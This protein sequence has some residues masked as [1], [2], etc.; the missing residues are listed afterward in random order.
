MARKLDIDTYTFLSGE[1]V[2]DITSDRFDDFMRS[3]EGDLRVEK[4]YATE[5]EYQLLQGRFS[6][7][8]QII[9]TTMKP[10]QEGTKTFL[11]T[12]EYRDI[13]EQMMLF[14]DY[15][16]FIAV[17]HWNQEQNRFDVATENHPE[18]YD[19]WNV[20]A[21]KKL[22][23]EIE[24]RGS[25]RLNFVLEKLAAA[26][27]EVVQDKEEY[28]W[29]KEQIDEINITLEMLE[30]KPLAI[31]YKEKEIRELSTSNNDT[32]TR[33]QSLVRKNILNSSNSQEVI[34]NLVSL[35]NSKNKIDA[36]EF[37][38]K[39]KEAFQ[40]D[41]NIASTYVHNKNGNI[42]LRL[43]NH[44]ANA[45]D[46]KRYDKSTSIVIKLA[47][48][49]NA[50]KFRKS[51]E[52]DLIEFAYYPENLT[53]ESEKAIVNGL[54]DWVKTGEYTYTQADEVHQSTRKDFIKKHKHNQKMTYAQNE[55]IYGFTYDGK[56]YLNPEIANSEV[57]LHEY[58]HLWDNYTQRTNPEL[59]EKGKDIL[60]DTKFWNEVKNDP[61]Y[62]DFADSDDLLLSEV[63]AQ[64]C[65]K[66][67]ESVLS[68]IQEQ[69]GE[70]TKDT[71]IDWD[72]EVSEF[73]AKEFQINPELGDENYISEMIRAENLK[74][75]LSMPMKDFMNGVHITQNVEEK[76]IDENINLSDEI[77]KRTLSDPW[78]RSFVAPDYWTNE[79]IEHWKALVK[80]K[81]VEIVSS[82]EVPY[83]AAR[84]LNGE[85]TLDTIN[86]L[87]ELSLPS[88][89][90]TVDQLIE[91]EKKDR[92]YAWK[93]SR[94]TEEERA[95]FVAGDKGIDEFIEQIQS[96]G[97]MSEAAME[98][99]ISAEENPRPDYVDE[100][101]N[102]HSFDEEDD[103][104]VESQEPPES[105]K[106]L[107][108]T[109][110]EAADLLKNMQ[111]TPENYKKLLNV[112][113]EISDMNG[114]KNL[115]VPKEEEIASKMSEQNNENHETFKD[116]VDSFSETKAGETLKTLAEQT[117]GL[118][119]GSI[120]T[121]QAVQDKI[122]EAVHGE[123][124]KEEIKQ[125]T[126]TQTES[127]ENGQEKPQQSSDG[128]PEIVF[129]E[130]TL[131]TFSVLVGDK[132]QP[133]ENAVVTGH[134]KNSGSYFVESNG[135]KFELPKATFDTLFNDKVEK[136]RQK[137]R[138]AE[139][140]TIVFGDKERGV[141]GT[142]I[143]EW[144]MYTSRGLETFKGFVPVK[145]NKA[146]DS[147][148]L[149]NGDQTLTVTAEK[150]REITAPE[151]FENKFD[152][153]SPAWKKLC[154]TQYKDFF[155]PRDST[156][157]NFR[158]NLSVYCRR[159]AT[160][161]CDALR[162]AKG[163]IEKMPKDEQKKTQR[164]LKAMA[165]ENE[166]TME[167][168]ARLYHE[169]IKEQ[170][171]NEDYMKTWQPK[172]V[173]ARP[174][175]DT[176]SSDGQ[177]VDNDPALVRGSEDRNLK[178]GMSLKNV[179]IETGK[180]F[181]RGKDTMHFD[182]LK[183]ISSSKEG[184]SVTLMDGNKSIFKLPR[185][186]VLKFYKEQQLREMKHEHRQ[187]RSNTMTLGYA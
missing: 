10:I 2:T 75:F 70:L 182:E 173:V 184:N 1:K 118:P 178:I 62:A 120:E 63:H 109:L 99:E 24:D 52:S 76:S 145:F 104:G 61:N 155:E 26:G 147:Y 175:Y 111:F 54:M 136:E 161:P 58:T 39:L 160:S 119:E 165:H 96:N 102:P 27:I 126:L 23:E 172:K 170:P 30:E 51:P 49:K 89:I 100:Q 34:K 125:E 176:I 3:F 144:S 72:K 12:E 154:E 83:H 32:Q 153:D 121:A 60:K 31:Q 181:G 166:S 53:L 16:Q 42:E 92:D 80:E 116:A 59:W 66:M 65:G 107:K 44:C 41:K 69:D 148:T 133:I 140:K 28:Q 4:G 64:I 7:L 163:L 187:N 47:R 94:L 138:I 149:S 14:D 130:T 141:K 74:D 162:I 132:M 85:E 36:E 15:S 122:Y 110:G 50:P 25:Q 108:S 171:L 151:R 38:S 146:E 19:N 90:E 67:A 73:I 143:P 87:E 86:N 55:Q 106:L 186:T 123:P 117:A 150:F 158:H 177:K 168:I 129:G 56:I 142:E 45:S 68:R 6:I 180:L 11:S 8:K 137:A 101:G 5:S 164:L 18:G 29:M 105:E 22:D 114:L 84:I 128:K 91:L 174:F 33:S 152:E 169:A 98:A 95:E 113:N 57:A 20:S 139:G 124:K 167:L 81:D 78:N 48:G 35:G 134:D 37:L 17:N 135:E 43:S 82:L 93:F 88:R 21:E 127:E 46:S 40:L 156:A 9:E 179:D 77:D 185:D 112:I 97:G 103:Y 159:E 115:A 157:Y 79:D 13:Q 183:V 131:P 71:V